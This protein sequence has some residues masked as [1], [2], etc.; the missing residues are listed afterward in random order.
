VKKNL[1]SILLLACFCLCAHAQQAPK[2]EVRAAW[3]AT[4]F[5]IDWPKNKTQ[6]EVLK[7]AAL[8]SLLDHHQATGINTI[9]FQIRSQCDAM[10]ASNIEPWSAD[11]TGKQGTAPVETDPF[12]PTSTEIWDPLEFIIEECHRRGM[13]LHAWMNPY[14][15][16]G[17]YG[18]INSFSPDHVA[19]KHPEWLLSAGAL[20]ILDPGIPEVQAYVNSVIADV[21]SRY[22]VDGVHFDDYFYPSA[23]TYNDDATF[24]ADP[25]GFTN[26]GDWRRDN[27]NR[28]IKSVSET[29]EDIKPWVKFGV[30]PSGIYRNSTDPA[31]GSATRGLQHYVTLFADSRKWL[32]EGWIDYLVPQ[33]YW[34]IGQSVADYSV[35]VPWWNDNAYG[36]HIYIG[37]AGYKVNV[38]IYGSS[39][40][41]P[42]MIPREVRLNRSPAYPNIYGQSIYNTSSL[43]STSK[44]GFRD[45]LRLDFYKYPALIPQMPWRD[46]MAPESPTQL[47]GIRHDAASVELN[48]TAPSEAVNEFDKV[49]RFVIYRSETPVIDFD[50]PA[51]IVAMTPPSVTTYTDNQLPGDAT[52]YYAV[53]SIDR[54]SN[55]SS[56]SNVTDYLPPVITCVPNQTPDLD[57]FCKVTLPD[58]TAETTVTD[59]VSV[60]SAISVVQSPA[61]GTV[62]DGSVVTVVTLTATDASGK[63]ASCILTV[64]GKDRMA[65]E[66]T[67]TPENIAANTGEESAE[68]SAAVTWDEPVATDNCSGPLTYVSRTHAPGTAFAVGTTEVTYVF[69]DKAGNEGSASFNVVVTDNAKPVMI[70]QNIS[71]D[72]ADGQ[73][74]LKA[75][76]VNNGSWDNCGIDVEKLTVSPATFTCA[77]IGENTVTLWAVD[78]NGN[79]NTATA[80]V[81]VIGSI[82]EP[83]VIISRDDDTFT[84][85]TDNGIALGY[86]A[87]ALTLTVVNPTH[88][89]GT[90][91]SWSPVAGL[92]NTTGSTTVFTPSEEGTYTF[93]VEAVNEYGC[94]ATALVTV[95]VIDARC[96]NKGDKVLV[97]RREGKAT[98]D[99]CVAPEAVPAQIQNGGRLGACHFSDATPQ[100]EVIPAS[101]LTAYPNP[102][103]E[104]ITLQFTL[105]VS[106]NYARLDL[107]DI[108]GN[109]VMQLFEGPV[110][111]GQ[112]Q[113]FTLNTNELRGGIFVARLSTSSGKSYYVRVVRNE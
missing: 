69:R 112:D 78:V 53:T 41:D 38:G 68:C 85:L 106:E 45:S 1:L 44:L 82:P 88:S 55:E 76:D 13:E 64:T 14:R 105:P 72:L 48:W 11:L 24:N 18:V 74:I 108:Y 93:T 101:V 83:S 34:Y 36:R 10:Y 26:R 28:F 33:V 29:I 67:G 92:S 6:P 25:R 7:R 61:A 96:G 107:Y 8:I 94:V 58:Y 37:M 110:E 56:P 57:L 60:P 52:Y 66:I 81:T 65:P 39:W 22:D 54:L 73:V 49:K 43:L 109:K 30:S 87:Q 80:V 103:Q 99:V 102:F 51:N 104:Q 62:I 5:G 50:N 75:E 9:Y 100:E 20:R 27:V 2:R 97:C 79:E 35:I 32:Q 90:D 84:G 12:D 3:I 42:S 21:V 59:D 91:Y 40:A 23:Q 111:S 19:R 113:H 46:D 47:V 89:A 71:R 15:A 95:Y 31:L 98:F 17:N 4:Y 63:S 70:T 86:G 77:D 16:I